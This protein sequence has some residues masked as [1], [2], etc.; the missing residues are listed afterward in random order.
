MEQN[1]TPRGFIPSA[2][3]AEQMRMQSASC[4][5]L[6]DA[7][8]TAA[9]IASLRSMN[10]S[11]EMNSWELNPDEVQVC[12]DSR[13]RPWQLGCGGFGRVRP[14]PNNIPDFMP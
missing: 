14:L 8:G 4:E 9:S 3:L 12:L 5:S 6:D 2:R 11:W 13:N 7:E 10:S 1:G